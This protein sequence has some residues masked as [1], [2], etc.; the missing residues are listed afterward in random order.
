MKDD[1]YLP[2]DKEEKWNWDGAF[3]SSVILIFY[4]L[5]QQQQ[6]DLRQ[7]GHVCMHTEAI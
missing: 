6:T 1:V 4:F 5:K 3:K 7:M 2:Q